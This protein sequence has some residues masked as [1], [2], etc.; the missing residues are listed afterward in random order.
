MKSDF[1]GIARVI[2]AYAET[3]I[4]SRIIKAWD[5]RNCD[6]LQLQFCKSK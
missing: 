6:V 3:Y 1:K 4:E 2:S 5:I